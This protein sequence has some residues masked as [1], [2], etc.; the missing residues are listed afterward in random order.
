MKKHLLYLIVA[1]CCMA[2]DSASAAESGGAQGSMQQDSVPQDSMQQD[3]GLTWY[4]VLMVASLLGG[5]TALGWTGCKKMQ[6]IR[7]EPQPLEVK[8]GAEYVS[9]CEFETYKQDVRDNFKGVH[10]RINDATITLSEMRGKLDKI[11][12][13]QQEILS[14]LLHRHENKG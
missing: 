1:G 13:T 14:L 12:N 8:L 4:Q 5:G 11:D 7:V 3:S 9:K 2:A 6:A 10:A